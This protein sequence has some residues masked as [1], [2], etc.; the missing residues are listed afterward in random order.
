MLGRVRGRALGLFCGVSGG[1]PAGQ[2]QAPGRAK[3]EGGAHRATGLVKLAR[4]SEAGAGGFAVGLGAACVVVGLLWAPAARAD[5]EAEANGDFLLSSLRAL[6]AA[7]VVEGSW[8]VHASGLL[9]ESASEL[10]SGALLRLA[11]PYPDGERGGVL[12]IDL[13]EPHT[14]AIYGLSEGERARVSYYEVDGEGVVFQS[15]AAEG[16]VEVV[17]WSASAAVTSAI[18]FS[19]RFEDHGPDGEAG[20]DDDRAVEITSGMA[21]TVVK[22]PKGP[23][24][25][26]G[27]TGGT[28]GGASAGAGGT[29]SWADPWQ[30]AETP[31]TSSGTSSGESGGCGSSSSEEDGG[32]S[33]DEY[34]SSSDTSSS[35]GGC[36]G[37]DS[38]S[39]EDSSSG[40][41]GDDDD[42]SACE[43]D[44][45]AA[46][47]TPR[48]GRRAGGLP[49]VG[50]LATLL[51]ALAAFQ[52]IVR[53]RGRRRS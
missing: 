11:F 1:S 2:P 29:V 27:T 20:S 15:D 12:R 4:R 13:R 17:K 40:C 24:V 50:N 22:A 30:P 14:G 35:S 8:S 5:V 31:G 28:S 39:S 42:S 9:S 45:E 21:T 46:T 34:D 36:G 33:S 41:R 49:R 44:A 7:W 32:C 6:P 53:R 26:A 10:T 19:L 16:T 52:F 23:P 37:S 51:L 48:R 18:S 25:G 43:S 47:P 38:S 3:D